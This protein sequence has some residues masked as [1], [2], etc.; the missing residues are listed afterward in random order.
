MSGRY[1]S[2]DS[3]SSTNERFQKLVQ[4]TSKGISS[5]HQLIR[6][7]QQKISLIGTPQDTRI[8]HQQLK[9]LSEKGNKMVS[10]IN[11]RLQELNRGT[12]GTQGRPRKTQVKKLSSDYKTQ[13]ELFETTCQKLIVSEQQSVDYIR[14]SSQSFQQER[15]QRRGSRERNRGHSSASTGSNGFQLGDYNEDQLYAQVNITRYDEDGM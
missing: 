4:E 7:M 9:E 6:S 15:K 12:Q 8:N 14:R 13:V 3:P 2:A 10:R 11:R 1:T 5:F